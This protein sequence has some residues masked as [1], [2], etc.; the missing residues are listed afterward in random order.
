MYLRLWIARVDPAAVERDLA[1]Y[2][3]GLDPAEVERAYRYRQTSDRNASL[4]SRALLRFALSQATP[5][6]APRTWR[7][8]TGEHGKPHVASPSGAH[9]FSDFNL[10]HSGDRVLCAVAAGCDVGVDIESNDRDVAS[11]LDASMV[12][13][14]DEKARLRELGEPARSLAFFDR[15]ALKE[16]HVK[17]TGRGLHSPLPDVQ[18]DPDHEAG[19]RVTFADTH[20]RTPRYF[21]YWL[22]RMEERYTAALC[23]RSNDPSPPPLQIKDVQPFGE[24]V[25][26]AGT[27]V[28]DVRFGTAS[29]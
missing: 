2:R 27:R 19:I 29:P 9:G 16:A 1:R 22:L 21:H 17:A 10:S 4:V 12:L 20:D 11:L 14:E 13:G 23:V 6:A 26:G 18:F 28:L 25:T 8:A 5:V 24:P 15:W 3:Q 7:F